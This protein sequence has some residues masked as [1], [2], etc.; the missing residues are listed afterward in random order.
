[1]VK[2][3]LV[4]HN[5]AEECIKEMPVKTELEMSDQNKRD[6]EKAKCCHMCGLKFKES[7]TKVRDHDHRTGDFRGAAHAK[8]NINYLSSRFFLPVLTHDFKGYDSHL[9]TNKKQIF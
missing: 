2:V 9:I 8:Y 1:M 4:L 5:I 3:V 6:F 7:D